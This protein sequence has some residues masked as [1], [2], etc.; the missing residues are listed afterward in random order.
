MSFAA[1]QPDFERQATGA[2]VGVD[3]G[4][5]HGLTTSDGR[6]SSP[7]GLTPGETARLLR[8][9]RK[10]A[11]Q[12]KGS[13]RREATRLAIAKLRAR[14]ADRRKDWVETESTALVRSNDVVAFEALKVANMTRSARGTIDNPGSNVAQKAGLDRAILAVG[15]GDLRRRVKDK[16]SAATSP[17]EVAEVNPAF[18]S[19]RCAVCGHVAPES[20]ESQSRF[21]CVACNHTANADVNAAINILAAGLAVHGRGDP[22]GVCEASTTNAA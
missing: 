5:T 4:V 10:M 15:W 6:H 17:V 22:P 14:E 19:Q 13:A 18:T 16:A 7:V 11:R 9:Q 8:L 1:A 21:R 12:Q 3:L 20:R 2:V